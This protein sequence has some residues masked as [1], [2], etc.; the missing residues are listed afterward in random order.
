MR[1]PAIP[2]T[3]PDRDAYTTVWAAIVAAWP[4]LEDLAHVYGV[5]PDELRDIMAGNVRRPTAETTALI[6]ALR[7]TARS[8][9]DAVPGLMQV[10][11]REMMGVNGD[12]VLPLDP[13]NLGSS[14]E[15][16]AEF[17]VAMARLYEADRDGRSRDVIQKL[18]DDFM[19]RGQR[20]L[21]ATRREGRD[22]RGTEDLGGQLLR[23]VRRTI[24]AALRDAPE[25]P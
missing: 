8:Q 5:K 14:S 19:H 15:E 4:A 25:D 17:N 1:Q 21:A 6:R 3:Q 16:A 13:P 24:A 10:V 11:A 12:F 2:E 22:T 9:P 18:G 20:L 7:I 23:H